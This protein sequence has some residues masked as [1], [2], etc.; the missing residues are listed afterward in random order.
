MFNK[1]QSWINEV[2]VR[3]HTNNV[4]TEAINIV[5]SETTDNP[6]ITVHHYSPEKFVGLITLWETGA[7]FVEVLEYTSGNTVISKLL[8]V[9]TDSDFY[10]VFKE[11]ISAIS[12]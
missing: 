8:E 3:L 7:A 2:K 11:Y 5:D 9:E 1:F 4:E 10:E 6:S 12:K